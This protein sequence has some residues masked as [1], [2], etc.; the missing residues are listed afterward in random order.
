[1]KRL[2]AAGFLA[3]FLH[4]GLFLV[5]FENSLRRPSAQASRQVMIDLVDLT[6][7]EAPPTVRREKVVV[8][9][10]PPK[11]LMQPGPQERFQPPPVETPAA[12]PALPSPGTVTEDPAAFFRMVNPPVPGARAEGKS[13]EFP[14]AARGKSGK[15]TVLSE[16]VPLYRDNPPPAYPVLARKRGYEGT[17]ILEVLVNKNGR[18][19]D[20]KIYHSSG[21]AVLDEAALATVKDWQFQPGSR[22]ETAIDMWVRVPI[23]FNLKGTNSERSQ[24]S[25][26]E[27]GAGG[28]LWKR[29]KV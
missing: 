2:L 12:G 24:R 16:A 21:Y 15:E 6:R 13:Q 1:V 14:S 11:P 17:V 7:P 23:R 25:R 18:V 28:R 19:T 10:P 4:V 5:P 20:L 27:E 29:T 3:A 26:E 9:N 8:K 22:G